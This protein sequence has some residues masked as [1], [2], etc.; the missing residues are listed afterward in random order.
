MRF[1]LVFYENVIVYLYIT[2]TFSFLELIQG[3]LF[4]CFFIFKHMFF[5]GLKS[6]FRLNIIIW[7][8]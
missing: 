4:F 5:N 6:I 3:K 8:V 1:N 7:I 2:T